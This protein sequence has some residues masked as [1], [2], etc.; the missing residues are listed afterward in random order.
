MI[1]TTSQQQHETLREIRRSFL[2]LLKPPP[3]ITPSQWA[4][5]HRVIKPGRSREPGRWRNRR[6]P[7]LVGIMD[8]AVEPGVAGIVVVKGARIGYSEAWKNVVGYWVDH[9]PDPLM[10]VLPDRESADKIMHGD[11]RPL[12]HET[13]RLRQYLSENKSDNKLTLTRLTSMDITTG[14]AGSA[15]SLASSNQRRVVFDETDKFDQFSGRDADPISLGMARANTYAAVGRAFY[16]LGSTPTTRAGHISRRADNC[17]QHRHWHAPCPHCDTEQQIVWSQVKWSPRREDED[18]QTHAARIGESCEAWYECKHCGGKIT[19]QHKPR[20]M[21]AGRWVANDP[22]ASNRWVCFHAPSYIS[23]MI[24]WAQIAE[25][26]IRAQGSP[27]LL[28]E[29]VNQYL[30]ESFE[31]RSSETKPDL[32][33]EKAK[34]AGPPMVVPNWAAMLIAT[35][36]VQKDHLWYVIRAWGAGNRSQLVRYGVCGSFDELWTLWTQPYAREATGEAV[37]VQFAGVDARYRQDE[38][39]A[40]C[41]RDPAHIIPLIGSDQLRASPLVT[42]IVKAYPGVTKRTI[43]PNHWKDVWHGL[44]HDDDG[45]RWMPHSSIGDDYAKQVSA[46]HRVLDPN[47]G[48]YVWEPISQG[49]DNHLF[50]CEAMQCAVAWEAGV[51][52]LEEAPPQAR[53][54]VAN[55]QYSGRSVRK[56]NDW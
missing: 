42:S 17:T 25:A 31:E 46:E 21:R 51:P 15:Q 47:K 50:D 55:E 22:T 44:A 9:D 14:W 27:A 48:A 30:G 52:F 7:H 29:V 4:E 19:E 32:I 33:N 45:T 10:F 1:L 37:A 18:R 24:T 34:H 12:L 39:Y 49:A 11:I 5:Q 38:V 20:M 26:W 53:E 41:Q 3:K 13:P 56:T 8:A 23:L 36:D 16:M 54:P 6:S 2:R 43:N 35:A 28:M 40:F